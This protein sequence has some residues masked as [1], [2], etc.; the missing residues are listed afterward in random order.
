[1]LPD[2][3]VDSSTE[4]QA[5]KADTVG[6]Q[7]IF[8]RIRDTRR[9]LELHRSHPKILSEPVMARLQLLKKIMKLFLLSS[10][11]QQRVYLKLFSF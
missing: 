4:W 3:S 11:F 1:M 8:S 5:G 9:S 2:Q 7:L 6:K 10:P